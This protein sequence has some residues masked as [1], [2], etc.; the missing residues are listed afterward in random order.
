M[1]TSGNNG[2]MFFE[3]YYT[4]TRM[5][6]EA[7][8]LQFYD[9]IIEY[10]ILNKEPEL[11]GLML[12]AFE[13]V[14]PGIDK[15]I[16]IRERGRKGGIAKGESYKEKDA[17][18]IAKSKVLNSQNESAKN[19]GKGREEKGR[20]VEGEEKRIEGKKEKG[21]F[22]PP[23]LDDVAA[24]CAERGNSIDPQRFIDFYQSKGWKV[25]SA[26]MK[27][28]K[29]AVRNWESR[30]AAPKKADNE[31]EIRQYYQQA[32]QLYPTDT[33]KDEGWETFRKKSKGDPK[34]ARR[35]ANCI[36]EMAE[37]YYSG[38]VGLNGLDKDI[39]VAYEH[40]RG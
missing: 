3:N 23:A 40:I 39:E 30:D 18:Y 38:D 31:A 26:P 4:A 15:S 5:M 37:Q 22:T 19:E 21:R 35:I 24:Y 7:Q 28:W 34:I 20:E 33:G 13:L 27:D 1:M 29:A 9:A 8:R 2:F 6:T 16:D 10:G 17:G 25:G 14:R 32:K 12:S 11:D 36:G